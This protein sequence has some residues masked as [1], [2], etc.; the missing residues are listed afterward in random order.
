MASQLLADEA[1]A[2]VD[3]MT[4]WLQEL[5]TFTQEWQQL[6]PAQRDLYRDVMLEIFQNLHSLA[7]RVRRVRATLPP[8]STLAAH[9]RTHTGEPPYRRAFVQNMQLVGHQRTHTGER[10]YLCG[11]C[12]KAFTLITKLVDHQRLHTAE[13]PFACHVCGRCFSKRSSLLGHPRAPHIPGVREGLTREVRPGPPSPHAHG[14]AACGCPESAKALAQSPTLAEQQMRTDEK[15]YR[16]LP[17]GARF[18]RSSA[19]MLCKR[20]QPGDRPSRCAHQ[21]VQLARHPRS[22]PGDRPAQCSACGRSYSQRPTWPSS[23]A[24]TSGS[25]PS[26]AGTAH[27]AIH[28][29]ERPSQCGVCGKSTPVQHGRVHTSKPCQCAQCGKAFGHQP[30]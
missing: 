7:L 11:D 28:S 17:C 27:P 4:L 29:D 18:T 25:G 1:L 16:C 10:P 2:W 30:R 8:D 21:N 20:L 12:S 15:P 14:R 3:Q 22:H 19:L 13:N 6:E 9:R 5:V 26:R 23:S 24:H